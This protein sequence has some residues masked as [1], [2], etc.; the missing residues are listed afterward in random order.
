MEVSTYKFN[1][2]IGT[3]ISLWGS[4]K[5]LLVSQ[6]ST[7]GIWPHIITRYLTSQVWRVMI[8]MGHSK[9]PLPVVKIL[10]DF[11]Y[12]LFSNQIEITTQIITIKY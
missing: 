7:L 9:Y 2:V 1:G 3:C 4:V 10:I 12:S 5:A 8:M 11:T 6:R